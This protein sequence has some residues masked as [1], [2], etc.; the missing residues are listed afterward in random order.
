MYNHD[1]NFGIIN[2]LKIN[3]ITISF[4]DLPECFKIISHDTCVIP[5]PQEYLTG[6]LVISGENI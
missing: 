6:K 1:P 2:S 5:V 4:G 3:D